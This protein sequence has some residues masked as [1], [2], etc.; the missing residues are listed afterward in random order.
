MK[1]FKGI[2]FSLIFLAL[3]YTPLKEIVFFSGDIAVKGSD[4]WQEAYNCVMGCIMISLHVFGFVYLVPR[5][6]HVSQFRSLIGAALI[7]I[8][9]VLGFQA[10][11]HEAPFFRNPKDFSE[12]AINAGW[13]FIA[14]YC[15][16][17][18]FYCARAGNRF[19]PG[20]DDG[21]YK[22]TVEKMIDEW[23]ST[24]K[25]ANVT[26]TNI[27]S[28]IEY[29]NSLIGMMPNDKALAEV[30][31]TA[32]LE[33]FINDNSAYAQNLDSKLAMKSSQAGYEYCQ[34]LFSSNK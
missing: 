21:D 20:F 3:A 2:L 27:H 5:I 23:G 10:L 26:N 16:V 14:I 9:I 24:R 13:S 22:V 1:I 19:I 29:R 18:G 7:A 6:N 28:I 30:S 33:T 25:P 12:V 32:G 15:A 17:K 34:H 31:K 8:C 11:S 4:T